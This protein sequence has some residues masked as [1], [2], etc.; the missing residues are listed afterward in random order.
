MNTNYKRDT[1]RLD[2]LHDN[3]HD[4]SLE[5]LDIDHQYWWKT[6]EGRIFTDFRAAIDSEIEWSEKMQQANAVIDMRGVK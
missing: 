2:W 5:R 3:R 4:I 1:E 6:S